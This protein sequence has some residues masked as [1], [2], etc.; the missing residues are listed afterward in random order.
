MDIRDKLHKLLELA[1]HGIGGEAD[2]ARQLLDGLLRKHGMTITDLTDGTASR[3][4]FSYR[5]QIEKKLLLQILATVCGYSHPIFRQRGKRETF[6]VDVTASQ[7]AEISLLWS[8]HRAYLAKECDALFLA[9]VHKQHLFPADAPVKE[10]VDLSQEEEQ[11]L[12]RM[13]Q[14]M[15]GMDRV[16]AHPQLAAG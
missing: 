4:R 8:V 5:G 11:R 15:T 7:N 3:R 10:A 12:E 1:R 6:L 13:H 9:Y 14:M 16:I 2:N